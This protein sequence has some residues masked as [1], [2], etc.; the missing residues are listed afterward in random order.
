[1][2]IQNR[3]EQARKRM[4]RAEDSL[5]YYALSGG[6]DLEEY[7]RLLDAAR[8]TRDEFLSQAHESTG[9]CNPVENLSISCAPNYTI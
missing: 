8:V 1:M 5:K 2:D 3:M 7:A 6:R 4:H 9:S